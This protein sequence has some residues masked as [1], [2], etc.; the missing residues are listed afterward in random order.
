[1]KSAGIVSSTRVAICFAVAVSLFVFLQI[2][3]MNGDVAPW[4]FFVG[5]VVALTLIDQEEAPTSI[6]VFVGTSVGLLPLA[7]FLPLSNRFSTLALMMS[8]FIFAKGIKV[9]HT[10]KRFGLRGFFAVSPAIVGGLFTYWWWSDLLKGSKEQI[11]TRLMTQWD[12]STHFL[13]F[14]SIA[15]DGRYLILSTPPSEGAVWQGRDYPAG[16]HYVW[17]QFA[18]ALREVSSGDRSVLVPFFGQAIVITGAAAVFV[19]SLAFARLGHTTLGQVWGGV[20]GSVLGATLFCAGPLSAT[21]WMGY[22]NAPAVVIG[23]AL[24]VTFLLMPHP[25]GRAQLWM[26]SAGAL[27]LAL[28]WYPTVVLFAPA[29]VVAC[30]KMYSAKGRNQVAAVSVLLVISALPVLWLL[31]NIG[32]T[33]IVEATGG[34]NRFPEQLLIGGSIFALGAAILLIGKVKAEIIVMLAMPGTLLYGLGRYMVSNVGDL[35]Y[36][37]HKFGLFVGTYLIIL[38]VGLLFIY[39][40]RNFVSRSSPLGGRVR[41]TV[42][43]VA[44]SIAVT[45]SFGYWG[46]ELKGLDAQTSGPLARSRLMETETKASDFL[47]LSSIVLSES[48]LNRTRSFNERTCM[49]LVLPKSVATDAADEEYGL[50]FGDG[51]PANSLWLAN[52]WFQALSDSATTEAFARTSR[53]TELGRVFDDFPSLAESRID[54]TIEESFDPDEVCI[55][56]T[57]EINAELRKK[58]LAWRT[59]DIEP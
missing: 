19:I 41:L 27:A 43:V 46:P 50:V 28:N 42:G 16:I 44:V 5:L 38:I 47:P 10:E 25:D 51:D 34:V 9:S 55:L 4:W 29:L 12:L 21:F 54:E 36:Y 24:L 57:N 11:L 33:T 40:Q 1:M 18:F 59:F 35:R 26:F 6:L 58:S 2:L 7:G 3:G 20:I 49:L 39:W 31:R 45:Q 30:L 48:A 17:S 14:S 13:F 23:I 52:I 53:T 22:A 32:L 8:G 15:R 56:S 37:F